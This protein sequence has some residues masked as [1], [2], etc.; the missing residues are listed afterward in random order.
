MDGAFNYPLQRAV[1]PG[2]GS[3]KVTWRRSALVGSENA[4]ILSLPDDGGDAEGSVR[5]VVCPEGSE[6]GGILSLPEEEGDVQ[7]SVRGVV[8][9]EG[10]GFREI[11]SLPDDGGDAEGSVRGVVCPEGS[12]FREILSLPDGDISLFC[13]WVAFLPQIFPTFA[14][15]RRRCEEDGKKSEEGE[16]A[17]RRRCEEMERRVKKGR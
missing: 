8:C 14:A 2:W 7:G 15:R 13:F 4:E 3:K 12:G 5:G 16:A 10:S 9:P 1:A 17:W 6:N 11:L